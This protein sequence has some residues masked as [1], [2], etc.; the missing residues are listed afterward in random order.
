[1]QFFEHLKHS[2]GY[3]TNDTIR[4]MEK[5]E[6]FEGFGEFEARCKRE[7]KYE[8]LEMMEKCRR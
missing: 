4:G 8:E 2:K 7:G 5:T 1:M 3:F 6:L